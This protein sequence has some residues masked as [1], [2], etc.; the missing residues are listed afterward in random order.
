MTNKNFKA[1]EIYEYIYDLTFS[2]TSEMAPNVNVLVFF[3]DDQEIISDS[4]SY[5][6]DK[7]FKNEVIFSLNFAIRVLTRW[8][9]LLIKNFDT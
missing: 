7:C 3:T 6:I 9:I 1:K 8:R 4:V 5:K 2:V